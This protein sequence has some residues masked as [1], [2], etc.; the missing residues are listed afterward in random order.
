MHGEKLGPLGWLVSRQPFKSPLAAVNVLLPFLLHM[1]MNSAS[2]GCVTSMVTVFMYLSYFIV[3]LDALCGAIYHRALNVFS[4]KQFV[5]Q[6]R[7]IQVVIWLVWSDDVT[8]AVNKWAFA[9]HSTLL[10]STQLSLP[11]VA[12]YALQI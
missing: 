7:L 1:W 6:T 8:L 4:P 12:M 10:P 5:Y 11:P 3:D 9:H 2:D